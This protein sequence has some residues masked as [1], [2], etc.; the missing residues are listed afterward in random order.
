MTNTKTK[1]ISIRVSEDDYQLLKD[2]HGSHGTRGMSALARQ[3][4]HNVI[5]QSEGGS[6][7]LAAEV[8]ILHTKLTELQHEVS[9]LARIVAEGLLSKVA[10]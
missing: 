7:D 4:L 9:R 2:R 1:M 8:S 5:H 6:V 10:N 3:A